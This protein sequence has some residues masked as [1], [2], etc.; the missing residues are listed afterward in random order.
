MLLIIVKRFFSKNQISF[1]NPHL[2]QESPNTIIPQ[3]V[4]KLQVKLN[5]IRKNLF[6]RRGI[7]FTAFFLTKL[8]NL[9]LSIKY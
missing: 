1:L 6:K 9:I 5:I 8:V 3:N 2:T 4:I 7:V